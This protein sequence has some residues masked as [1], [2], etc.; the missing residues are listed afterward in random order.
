MSKDR[1]YWSEL[2]A[3]MDHRT[4]PQIPV[5]LVLAL[6]ILVLVLIGASS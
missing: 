2:D 6:I 3:R 1:D 5:A 4:K